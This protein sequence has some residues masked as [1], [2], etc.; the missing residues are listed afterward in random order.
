M[1]RMPRSNAPI[2]S[3]LALVTVCACATPDRVLQPCPSYG[4]L[5]EAESLSAFSQNG[6]DA[7]NLMYRVAL[8]SPAIN[9]HYHGYTVPGTRR[10]S[11]PEPG[12]Q[13]YA[14]PGDN[15][16]GPRSDLVAP[17]QDAVSACQSDSDQP[18]RGRARKFGH[19]S[20]TMTF[21]MIVQAGPAMTDERITVP[22]FV[23][24]TR[25]KTF[26]LAR[27][28]FTTTIKVAA[29]QQTT[30]KIEV[31]LDIPLAKDMTGASYGVIAGLALTPDQLA[32]NR[33]Q[34]TH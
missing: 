15:D 32:Y 7:A 28:A 27:Q 22:Y 31:P 26:I 9:C 24:I 12:L 1:A 18:S 21:D 29:G 10:R 4:I 6:Q 20:A 3:L 13:Q 5:H 19:V 14:P 16:L 8:S 23:A 17:S 34:A 11:A 30:Q 33:Q 2:L 25:A